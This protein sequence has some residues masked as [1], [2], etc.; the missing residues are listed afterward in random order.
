VG[1]SSLDFTM[2]LMEHAGIVTTPGSGF[3]AAGEGYV[4][5]ALTQPVEVIRAMADGLA[6]F[7][8]T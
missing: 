6:A 7:P 2:R 5:F 4:R 1:I 3:G 8:T